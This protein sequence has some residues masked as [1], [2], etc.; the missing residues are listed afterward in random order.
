VTVTWILATVVVA[1][2]FYWLRCRY[3]FAY[4][5][6]ELGAALTIIFLTFVPQATY[7]MFEP[8][9]SWWGLLLSKGVGISAGIY[10]MVRALD[11]IEKGWP[12]SRWQRTRRNFRRIFFGASH[13]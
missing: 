6:I 11:N 8:G 2:C 10:V 4:G 5:V 12:Q 3:L 1:L 7:L 13:A 9:P